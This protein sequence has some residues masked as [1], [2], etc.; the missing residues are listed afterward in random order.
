MKAPPSPEAFA[1]L[2][3]EALAV[4]ANPHDWAIII[5]EES[6]WDSHR[7]NGSGAPYYGLNQAGV[8]EIRG[9]GFGEHLADKDI[10]AAWLALTIEQQLPYVCS[11]FK[12]KVHVCGDVTLASAAHML[13]A[14]FLPARMGKARGRLDPHDIDYPLCEKGEGTHFYE[15][16]AIYDPT[17]TGKI[18]IRDLALFLNNLQHANPHDTAILRGGIVAAMDDI[19]IKDTKLQATDASLLSPYVAPAGAS[20]VANAL[21]HARGGVAAVPP[22]LPSGAGASQALAPGAAASRTGL[23]IGIACALGAAALFFSNSRSPARPS[24]PSKRSA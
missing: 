5:Y 24:K 13:A 21:P 20:A 18:S 15:S 11:F 3:Q 17:H 23:V 14:N 16:N 4:G 6:T 19:G 12:K 22:P 8:N 2:A 10:P 1:I 9:M 7:K